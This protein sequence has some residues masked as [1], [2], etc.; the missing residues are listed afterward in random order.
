MV[1]ALCLSWFWLF[2]NETYSL[3]ERPDNLLHRTNGIL[4]RS[5][6]R[7]NTIV[8]N[9]LWT[10]ISNGRLINVRIYK[11]TSQRFFM[12]VN[13]L[14][15]I[16]FQFCSAPLWNWNQ[17]DWV[18]TTLISNVEKK[19]TIKIL[20]CFAWKIHFK[21]VCTACRFYW[22]L[23]KIAMQYVCV[24]VCVNQHIYDFLIISFFL[25]PR[26]SLRCI[27]E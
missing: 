20:W 2:R 22:I 10:T 18:L 4:R 27:Y 13:T 8:W 6:M 3:N 1:T 12:I 25:F 5:E 15:T 9:F 14:L 16:F 24:C 26:Y 7:I 11:F 17:N 23:S 19:I 21:W